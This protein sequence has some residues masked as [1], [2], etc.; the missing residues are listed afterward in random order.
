M[1]KEI[2]SNKTKTVVIMIIF[3]L[4]VGGLGY[5]LSW[6]FNNPAIFIIAIIVAVVQTLIS[7]YLADSITLSI[8]G[9]Q[10]APRKEPFLDLHR[11][12]ENIAIT[13]GIPKPKIY[14]IDDSAPNA[15]ATGRDP[16]HA[17]IAVTTGLLS[18]LDKNELEGVIAHEMGHI[19]NYDIRLMMVIVIL[20]GVASLLSDLFLRFTIFG[21][22]RRD[23]NNDNNGGQLQAILMI[24]GIVL[25]ILSPIIATLIQLSVS[26]KREYLADATGALLTRYPE[27]LASALEK[28][29][30]D[31]EPLEVANKA[32]AHLYIEDPLKD[33][34]GKESW[35]T[36]LFQTHPPV[37]ERIKK[38]RAMIGS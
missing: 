9:A 2:D 17:S 28:I 4:F 26:R 18:K 30:A 13:A 12:V 34:E 3:L 5:F 15:F 38:L 33:K 14:V 8:S 37:Q 35:L 20:V 7:Y 16:K 22:G 36:S 23:D 10:E 32:T 24:I 25:V 31:R 21:G 27:G 11:T 29:S 19:G 6:Y 1:Y